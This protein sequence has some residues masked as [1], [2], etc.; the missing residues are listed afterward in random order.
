MDRKK[1]L[2][3]IGVVT[4]GITSLPM[5]ESFSQKL[6]KSERMPVLFVGHG[7]PMNAI[8]ENEFTKTW[9]NMGKTLPRPQAILCVSAHWLTQGTHITA[10]E[11]PETIHDFGGFPQK[12]FDQQYPAPGSPEF[13]KET[14]SLF[15]EGTVHLT[16][17][18]GLDHGTWSVLI[19]MYPN[20]DIPVYQMSIDYSKS[21]QYHYELAKQ[22]STL[23]DH[24]VLIIGSGNIVH[25][26]RQVNWHATKPYDWAVE[27]NEKIKNSILTGN[28]KDVINYQN[29]GS[30]AQL[31]V[32]SNDHYL[33][34]MYSMGLIDRDKDEIS[35]FNDAYDLGSV[36]M[37]GIKIG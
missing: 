25:N 4:L 11:K 31:S 3:S 12:L 36:S 26:L 5:L 7:S 21:P 24:G 29:L 34:L 6:E 13:A 16:Q 23:R 30:A 15:D 19:K 32:P 35:V 8:L 33:P 18:W 27:F 9:E 17:E 1:F 10:M 14:A 20:A 28:H 22:L 37:T 2:K